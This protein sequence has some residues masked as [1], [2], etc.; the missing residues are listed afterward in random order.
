MFYIFANV[1][2]I[3]TCLTFPRSL[4]NN[5]E[6]LHKSR[7]YMIG[8]NPINRALVTYLPQLKTTFKLISQPT[9]LFLSLSQVRIHHK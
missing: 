4:Q 5:I 6:T 3:Q 9:E 1:Y 7:K 2:C 8:N